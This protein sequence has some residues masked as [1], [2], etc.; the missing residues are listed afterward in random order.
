MAMRNKS[1]TSATSSTPSRSNGQPTSINQSLFEPHVFEL[2]DDYYQDDANDPDML[3]PQSSRAD[4][5]SEGI[6]DFRFDKLNELIKTQAA[7]SAATIRPDKPYNNYRSRELHNTHQRAIWQRVREQAE[8]DNDIPTAL[9]SPPR[10]YI[11]VRVS[12]WP[13]SGHYCCHCDIDETD[14]EAIEIRAP[15]DSPNG[16]MKDM[17]IQHVSDALYGRAPE[18]VDDGERGRYR[19]GDENDRPVIEQFDY[20]IQ[21]SSPENVVN[22]MGHIFALTKGIVPKKLA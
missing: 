20:M 11:E 16:I 1:S 19:I 13:L 18:A 5:Y 7:E 22:I 8:A 15:R 4:G 17:F 2:D 14:C 9:F 6:H 12:K 10:T 21:G 3:D